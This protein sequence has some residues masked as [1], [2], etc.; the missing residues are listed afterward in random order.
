MQS[1]DCILSPMQSADCAGSQMACNTD[2]PSGVAQISREGKRINEILNMR[3]F[4]LCENQGA[5]N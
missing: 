4:T 2:N 5:E 1:A 3:F